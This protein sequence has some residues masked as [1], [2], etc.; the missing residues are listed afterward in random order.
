[1][2]CPWC[3]S[4]ASYMIEEGLWELCLEVLGLSNACLCFLV[5]AKLA[6]HESFQL[7]DLV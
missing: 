4:S 2:A 1:M 6:S 3:I 5:L 7:P